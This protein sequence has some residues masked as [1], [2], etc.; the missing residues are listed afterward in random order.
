MNNPEFD[1]PAPVQ[2]PPTHQVLCLTN[3]EVRVLNKLLAWAHHDGAM[4]LKDLGWSRSEFA[5]VTRVLKKL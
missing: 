5:A 1:D 2:K 3:Y 4:P